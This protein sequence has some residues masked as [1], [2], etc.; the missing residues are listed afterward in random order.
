MRLLTIFFLVYLLS[1]TSYAQ[2]DDAF[3]KAANN[4]NFRKVA[5]Q[6]K[7]QVRLRRYGLTCDNGT[8]SGI[9]VIHTYGLDTLTLWL[10]NH[11]CVVDA[12]WDKC[13][14]KPA[15]Y[16]GWAI[17]GACFNTR[18]GIKEECFYIQEGTLGNLW[19]FGW[20]P[21]LFKPK[22]ILTFKKHYQ[23]EGFVHQQNQNCEQSKNH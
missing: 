20:H 17:I 13:Q 7:K 5:R 22:N 15:I 10:R 18:D 3:C 11:S 23:S 4:G 12:A 21:H 9:Q 8:G 14:V 6:F 1:C 19:L 2:H 16:P